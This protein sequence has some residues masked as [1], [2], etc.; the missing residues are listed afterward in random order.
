MLRTPPTKALV[1][2]LQQTR[3]PTTKLLK[4]YQIPST[5]KT[6]LLADAESA[7]DKAVAPIWLPKPKQPTKK[8]WKL[9]QMPSKTGD[10]AVGA[11]IDAKNASTERLSAWLQS[12]K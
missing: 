2:G 12:C 6:K 5:L 9:L 10:K 11:R 7:V 1:A 4:P 8:L 3:Q